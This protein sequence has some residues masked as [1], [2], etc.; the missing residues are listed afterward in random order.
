M[1]DLPDCSF[2]VLGVINT[3]GMGG[4]FMAGMLGMAPAILP[5]V[6]ASSEPRLNL[7]RMQ[8]ASS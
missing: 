4:G 8:G 6:A 3:M 1:D 5:G 7:Y 2:A